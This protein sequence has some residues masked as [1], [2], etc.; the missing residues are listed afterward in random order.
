[1]TGTLYERTLAFAGI[2]QAARLVDEVA[3]TGVADVEATRISLQSIVI[4]NPSST[5]AVFENEAK[6][7]VGLKAFI[8]SLQSSKGNND[9]TRYVV[10]LLALERKLSANKQ[11]MATLAQRLSTAERQVQHFGLLD[12][13]MISNFASIYLDVI[14]PI[15]PRIQIVGN[16]QQ[17]QQVG[18]QHKVRALLL[19]GIR[20]T[21][22]WRQ[23]G[24][25]RLQI[26]FGRKKMFEQ[27]RIILERNIAP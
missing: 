26:L 2:C 23:L 14:S 5:A 24:G 20:S 27:A 18:V 3:R 17:L 1:M 15:G 21:V 10:N 25:S 4:L 8:N 22:L 6:L 9:V 19:A 13:Q 7:A 12:E 16:S 11:M